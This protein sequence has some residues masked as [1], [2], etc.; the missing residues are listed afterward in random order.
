MPT[1]SVTDGPAG[2]RA[3]SATRAAPAWRRPIQIGVGVVVATA[4]ISSVDPVSTHV[5]LCPLHA[6]TGLDCPACGGLRSVFSLTRGD[7]GA[8]A[9][10]H[11]LFTVAVPFLV[12]GWGLWTVRAVTRPDARRPHLPRWAGLAALTLVAVFT[13]AR[14]VPAFAWLDSA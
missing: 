2:H 6:V 14:N 4:A 1:L 10:H 12:L 3:P 9:S 5:P 8:A 13:I 11:L 7:I